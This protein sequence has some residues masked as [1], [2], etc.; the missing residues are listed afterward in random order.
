VIAAH[1]AMRVVRHPGR[2]ADRWRNR[3]RSHVC[4]ARHFVQLRVLPKQRIWRD[5]I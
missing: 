2:L 1:L 5:P 3:C 4:D